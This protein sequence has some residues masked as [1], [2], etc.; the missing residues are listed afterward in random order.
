MEAGRD[1]EIIIKPRTLKNM[2]SII[3]KQLRDKLFDQHIGTG[4]VAFKSGENDLTAFEFFVGRDN[5]IRRISDEI[6]TPELNINEY[7]IKK[8]EAINEASLIQKRYIEV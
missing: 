8:C 4:I 6:K 2:K 7:I 5:K 3:N 1:E